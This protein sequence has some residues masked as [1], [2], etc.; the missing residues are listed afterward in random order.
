MLPVSREST[1]HP[2]P[3]IPNARAFVRSLNVLL[4]YAR[5]Y[6]LEHTRSAGQLD[7]AWTELQAA[8]EAAGHG[9]L[10]LGASGSQLLLDGVPLESSPAERSFA[11][12][13]NAAGVA[14]IGFL[15]RVERSEF[16]NLV[17]CFMETG[18]KAGTLSERLEAYFGNRNNCGIRVNEIRFVAEDAGF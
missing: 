13:L 15:P 2:Q 9:G 10:L 12:L 5:L 11:D 16:A 18:P 4:K 6:G 3:T 14:S 8:V 7:S 17:K 1:V